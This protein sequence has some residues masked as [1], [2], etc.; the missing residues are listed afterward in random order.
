MD[1]FISGKMDVVS[2]RYSFQSPF[3]GD[4]AAE[5]RGTKV[6]GLG[7]PPLEGDPSLAQTPDCGVAQAEGVAAQTEEQTKLF[8]NKQKQTNKQTYSTEGVKG[9]HGSNVTRGVKT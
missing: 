5:P 4:R 8:G 3:P 9:W 6:R 7:S 2:P 1:I